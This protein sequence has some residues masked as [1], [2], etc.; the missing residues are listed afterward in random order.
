MSGDDVTSTINN[1]RFVMVGTLATFGNYLLEGSD[2]G[3]ST[4][5]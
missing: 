3:A 4:W 5:S 2:M 1:R